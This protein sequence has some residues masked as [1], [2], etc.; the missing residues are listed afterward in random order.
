MS[1]APTRAMNGMEIA[2]FS[3]FPLLSGGNPVEFLC[4]HEVAASKAVYNK[5][6]KGED[7]SWISSHMTKYLLTPD[8][9]T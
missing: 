5:C 3:L 9:A 7:H 1:S 8:N 6:R 2:I 4:L